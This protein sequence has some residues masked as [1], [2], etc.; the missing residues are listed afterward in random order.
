MEF[1]G[2]AY[3]DDVGRIADENF[4]LFSTEK[5]SVYYAIEVETSNHPIGNG[6][7]QP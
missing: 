7:T 1:I 2:M 6:S 5:E 3:P 4:T